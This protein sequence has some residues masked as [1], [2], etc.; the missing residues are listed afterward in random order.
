MADDFS[1]LACGQDHLKGR[2]AWNAVI[3]TTTQ[4]SISKRF[5]HSLLTA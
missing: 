4:R 2:N 5:Y 1:R 3:N